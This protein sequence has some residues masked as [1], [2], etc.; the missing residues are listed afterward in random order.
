MKNFHIP[1][2]TA[3]PVLPAGSKSS[4]GKQ[5]GIIFFEYVIGL[6]SFN[7]AIS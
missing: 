6:R 5:T 3:M 2:P 1:H 4:V 7:S